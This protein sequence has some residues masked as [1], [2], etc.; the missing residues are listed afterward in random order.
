[1]QLQSEYPIQT[2]FPQGKKR[3]IPG[4]S[5][6]PF[7]TNGDSFALVRPRHMI[8]A[9]VILYTASYSHKKNHTNRTINH[10]F[11]GHFDFT[12]PK[13]AAVLGRVLGTPAHS[14]SLHSFFNVTINAL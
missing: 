6:G 12:T 3:T 1:M 4:I 10:G 13:L 7:A 11:I 5:L 14:H 2:E 9:Y 8:F